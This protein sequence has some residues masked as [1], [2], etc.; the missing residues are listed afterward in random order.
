MQKS[1]LT[2]AT[3]RL[4]VGQLTIMFAALKLAGFIDWSWW[5]VFSP[6]WLPAAVVL[7]VMFTFVAIGALLD[8]I[9]G[10]K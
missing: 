2:A 10:E 5:W 1:D 4:L 9:R 6:F 8:L 7:F 3:Y